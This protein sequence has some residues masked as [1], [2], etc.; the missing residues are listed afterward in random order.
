MK[1]TIIVMMIWIELPT[2]NI[3][4]IVIIPKKTII[5]TAKTT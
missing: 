1:H 4:I 3:Q 5:I 2:G